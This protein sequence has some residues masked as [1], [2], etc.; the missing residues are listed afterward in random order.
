MSTNH[1]T[2]NHDP[3]PPP[4]PNYPPGEVPT[5][6]PFDGKDT[7][8]MLVSEFLGYVS[9]MVRLAQESIVRPP[10]GTFFLVEVPPAGKA[11]CRTFATL[12]ELVACART[13]HGKDTQLFCFVGRRLRV[14]K[15]GNYL[16]TP[17]GNHPLFLV[18]DAGEEDEDGFM[19][20]VPHFVPPVASPVGTDPDEEDEDEEDGEVDED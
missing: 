15:G 16:F 1:D 2:N 11:A 7:V 10:E 12:D 9:N 5:G 8:P 20:E 13:F 6:P 19:G 17:W 3:L 18:D 4:P 14:S